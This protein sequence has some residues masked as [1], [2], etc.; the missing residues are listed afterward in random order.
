MIGSS[1]AA[2]A[3]VWIFVCVVSFSRPIAAQSLPAPWANADIGSPVLGG[4]ASSSSGRFTID[5]AGEDIWGTRDQFHFVYQTVAGDFDLRA[6]VESLT[7][8]HWWSKAGV[9][10]RSSL[11]AGAVHGFAMVSGESGTGFQRRLAANGTSLHTAGLFESAPHWVRLTRTG[12]SL[13]AY[14]SIDGVTWSLVDTQALTLAETVYVGMAVTSHE[15]TMRASA[16]FSSVTLT[17]TGIASGEASADIGAPAIA[18]SVRQ[19]GGTYTMTAAGQDIWDKADQFHYVYRQVTGDIDVR[20]RVSSLGA[21][22]GW[23]KAGVMIRE[24]VSPGSRHAF[25]A[26]TAENG[27]V[28]QHRSDP[29]GWS[30]SI[31][32]G[33]GTAPGWVRLTRK[34]TL[35]EAFRSADGVSWVSIGTVAVPMASTVLVGLAATSHNEVTPTVAV[36]DNLTITAATAAANTPPVVGISA[37]STGTQVTVGATLTIAATA[38]DADGTISKVEF[39]ANGT[40]AGVDVSAPYSLGYRVPAAGTY[41]LTAVATDDKGA[42]TVSSAVTL[43]VAAEGTPAPGALPAGQAGKDIGSPALAGS[44]AYSGGVYTIRSAGQDIWRDAD[45]FHYLYQSVT[46]DVDVVARVSSMTAAHDWSKAGIMIRQSLERGSP[47]AMATITGAAGYALQSRASAGAWSDHQD[48]GGGAAPGWLRLVRTGSQIEAF[49]SVDG[50]QWVTMGK[51]MVPMAESILVGL[52]VSSVDTGVYTTAVVD[53]FTVTPAS[54][55]VNKS[56]SVV[57]SAP[58]GGTTLAAGTAVTITATAS[59]PDGTIA[60]VEF[61]ANGTPVGRDTVAPYSATISAPALGTYSLTAV[62]TDDKGSTAVST[63][64]AITVAA[65]ASTALPKAIAFTVSTDHD[66]L[67]SHYLLEVFAATATPGTTA[68]VATMDLGKPAANTSGEASV[69]CSA[70]FQA[71]PPGN[72]QATVTAV[73]SSGSA[74]SAPVSFTR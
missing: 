14:T 8:A 33:W 72:Y 37:P 68:P 4:S 17:R 16:T 52:A 56:P 54:P 74:R 44:T 57:I 19:A 30:D 53:R 39:Y 34:G 69:D 6:R 51:V 23:A 43:A 47:H 11:S 22:D 29:E 60:A 13:S 12:G 55:T 35:F 50:S 42:T 20:A 28:L 40:L 15:P 24:T 3:A 5:A 64:V 62:A 25:A 38:S 18:G 7:Q 66:T 26:M 58:A 71:L 61:F 21:T 46:G 48:G 27:Y 9:M 1:R 49:R 63:P 2:L 32:G 59:D 70:F 67:V 36:V 65:Q 45:Q 10:V 73:G 41:S 31:S